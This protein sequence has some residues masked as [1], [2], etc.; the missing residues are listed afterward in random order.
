MG[1]RQTP[2]EIDAAALL[3]LARQGGADA[4]KAARIL[5]AQAEQTNPALARQA[6]SLALKLEPMDATPRLALARMSAEAG[7]LDAAAAEAAHVYA[8]AVDQAA[9]ARAAFVLA[10]I[11]RVRGEHAKARA[12][13][14]SALKIED[15]IL[16]NDRSDPAA[17]RWYARA[18]G[19]IAEL[20]IAAGEFARARSGAEGALAMLRA[21]AAAIGEPPILAA[22]IADAEMRLAALDLDDNQPSSAR[23]R[24]GEAIG[25]YEALAVTE[26]DEPHWRA[27]LSDAWALAAQADG[28]R[29]AFDAA[30]AAMDKALQA[31]LVLA[32]RHDGE[33]WALAGCW[34]QRG[35]IRAALGDHDEAKQSFAQARLLV[36]RLCGP[37]VKAPDPA[38]FFARTL[39]EQTDHGLASGALGI[40]ADAAERARLLAESFAA[41]N[42]SDASWQVELALIWDRLGEIARAGGAAQKGLDGLARAVEFRR[43]ALRIDPDDMALL[44]GLAAAMLRLGDTMLVNGDHASA[45]AVLHESVILR[46][47]LLERANDDPRAAHALAA[48]LERLG[49]AALAGGDV[50]TARLAWA[51]ELDLAKLIFKDAGAHDALRF[52]AIVEAHLASAGGDDARAHRDAALGRLRILA[53]ADALGPAEAKLR[54]KLIGN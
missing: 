27:V 11:A 33:S 46:Q 29:G 24:L 28:A 43:R 25:R 26:K 13:Y 39:L 7:D 1:S 44:R 51:D 19:R 40:A 49:L 15:S 41:A 32:A 42:P 37:E 20:D 45:R 48:A 22:D 21:T 8:D 4:A 34:R 53:E 16:A 3:A 5:A 14:T 10:E 31:R 50:D 23:R 17:A 30:R 36:E 54:D 12:A 47:E 2:P 9:R 38:R 52:R 6:L 35:H 18:R